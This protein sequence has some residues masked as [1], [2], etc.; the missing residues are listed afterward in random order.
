MGSFPEGSVF[1]AGQEPGLALWQVLDGAY[2][3]AVFPGLGSA[4]LGMSVQADVPECDE[5]GVLS[6]G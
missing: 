4:G 6:L 5:C 1:P 2:N 3:W